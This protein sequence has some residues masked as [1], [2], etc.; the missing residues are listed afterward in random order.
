M[1]FSFQGVKQAWLLDGKFADHKKITC[2]YYP[3]QKNWDNRAPWGT[4]ACALE[5]ARACSLA[6]VAVSIFLARVV[7][8]HRSVI[9][10]TT[11]ILQRTLHKKYPEEGCP[12]DQVMHDR[13]QSSVE[14]AP[15]IT[16]TNTHIPV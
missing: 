4:G 11:T 5:H 6:C 13:S 10:D 2:M 16:D 3:G 1:G 12:Y 9:L 8:F 15:H 7:R 14:D